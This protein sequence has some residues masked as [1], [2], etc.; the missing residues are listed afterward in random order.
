MVCS[1]WFLIWFSLL[2]NNDCIKGCNGVLQFCNLHSNIWLFRCHW[3]SHVW[4]EYFITN[5]FKS[6]KAFGCLKSCTMDHGNNSSWPNFTFSN[7]IIFYWYYSV[8]FLYVF[9]WSTLSPSILIIK[10][11]KFQFSR[12]IFWFW[13]L[14]LSVELLHP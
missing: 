11:S 14:Q 1:N 10:T 13:L 7:P 9:R 3:L 6:S 8:I 12:V 4:W 5:H 2:L